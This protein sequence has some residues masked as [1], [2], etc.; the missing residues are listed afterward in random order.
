ME[1]L[2]WIT[3]VPLFTE[4]VGAV[5][6]M[7]PW[8]PSLSSREDGCW[9]NIQLTHFQPVLNYFRPL[10]DSL[11]MRLCT[12]LNGLVCFCAG[13]ARLKKACV[14]YYGFQSDRRPQGPPAGCRLLLCSRTPCAW[15]PCTSY[16]A[17]FD[18]MKIP[19][20][21]DVMNKFEVLGI[22]G[23]GEQNF[24]DFCVFRWLAA[25]FRVL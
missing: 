25:A 24:F 2:C 4:E 19:D 12:I 22:V 7:F 1:S 13:E 10:P 21:G 20:I 16:D 3:W 14:G 17:P 8:S 9:K 6:V 15:A 18:F 5:T 11:L 23:E